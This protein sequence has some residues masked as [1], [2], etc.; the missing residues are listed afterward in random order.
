M[1]LLLL[2]ADQHMGQG[3]YRLTERQR[4]HV[5]HILKLE[6]GA[7]CRAGL[8]NGPMGK[9]VLVDANKTNEL[10]GLFTAEYDPPAPLP[11]SLLLA[12]PRPKMLKR[13]LIDAT[14]LGVKRIVLLNSWKVDK[15]YW[16]TPEL[17][18]HQLQWKMR[19]GLEQARDTQMPEVLL[20]HR[21][22]PFVE[23]QLAEWLRGDCY[24]AHPGP[25]PRL[26]AGRTAET[27]LALGPE[28]G[29]T[30]YE[31]D[32]L[33]QHGFQCGHFGQR[34]L[35]AETALPAITAHIMTMP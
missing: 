31:I 28:G 20:A 4:D 21:F 34:I 9:L 23:D 24:V 2:D 19:L 5:R 6:N 25:Y 8:L 30:D 10:D 12:L 32:M 7:Q 16:Q 3:R 18:A 15:S 27:T 1:N 33:V 26:P 17:K 29:W 14:S 35:R 13:M 11:L 22:K